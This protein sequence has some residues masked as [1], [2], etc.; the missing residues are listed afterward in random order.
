M[1]LWNNVG[2]FVFDKLNSIN[3]KLYCIA[4]ALC[5]S[6]MNTYVDRYYYFIP[7]PTAT[8]QI[9]HNINSSKLCDINVFM[10]V[11]HIFIFYIR[12]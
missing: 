8:F 1:M 12:I 2:K 4:T 7:Q 9:F 6:L 10:T 11:I 3:V 5:N